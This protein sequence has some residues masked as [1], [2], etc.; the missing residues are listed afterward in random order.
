VAR[1]FFWFASLVLL[2]GCVPSLDPATEKDLNSPQVPEGF[3][4]KTVADLKCPINDG[5]LRLATK[6]EWLKLNDRIGA[7]KMKTFD[8]EVAKKIGD[9]YLIREDGKYVYRIEG[10][11]PILKQDEAIILDD[12][13]K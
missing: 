8:G 12:K 10:T 4:E 7:F 11:A 6:R 2:A 5:K 9:G 1:V 13:K 3:D